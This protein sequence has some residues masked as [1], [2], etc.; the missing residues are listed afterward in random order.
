M[1][2]QYINDTIYAIQINE[3][4]REITGFFRSDL[5]LLPE[6]CI[7]ISREDWLDANVINSMMYTEEGNIESYIPSFNLIEYQKKICILIDNDVT[8]IRSQF[9]TIIPMQDMIYY[10][11]KTEAVN[12]LKTYNPVDEDFI[13]LSTEAIES[14]RPIREIAEEIKITSDSLMKIEA[15]IE[16]L[17][18]VAKKKIKLSTV[19]EEI[20]SIYETV[21]DKFN[22]LEYTK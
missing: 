11:K 18:V 9:F 8:N 3:E 15:K 2:H 1:N 19:K 22:L 20:D 16:A 10:A 13:F 14:N 5:A 7:L 6:D 17:R 21:S 12:Y 4:T